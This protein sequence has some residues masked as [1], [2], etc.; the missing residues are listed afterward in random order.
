MRSLRTRLILSHVLPLLVI[1]PLVGIALIYVLETQVLLTNLSDEL[2][3]QAT[4]TADLANDHPDIW[5]DANSARL[6]VTR[7][8]AHHKSQVMLLDPSGK[9]P[10][11]SAGDD[12]E[13]LGQM[14]ELL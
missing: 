11:S 6:F 8:S 3:R 10:A 5:Q 9:L 7:F 12:Q 14:L 4:L 2:T 13:R 1:V